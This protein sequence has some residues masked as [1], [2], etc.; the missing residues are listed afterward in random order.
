MVFS[1]LVDMLVGVVLALSVGE[2]KGLHDAFVRDMPKE[3]R[4][5]EPDMRDVLVSLS[6]SC[7]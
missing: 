4:E 5:A 7:Q 2:C 6:L 1:P 3:R